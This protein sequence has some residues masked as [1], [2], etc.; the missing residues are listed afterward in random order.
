MD[1]PDTV[2]EPTDHIRQIPQFL[3]TQTD[4]TIQL[5]RLIPVA[6]KLG[7]YD[8]ADFLRKYVHNH[9]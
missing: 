5:E 4:L 8:A 6:N 3:Q 1:K 2:F 9:H 7:L